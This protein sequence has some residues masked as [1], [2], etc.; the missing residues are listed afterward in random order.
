[1]K[2]QPDCVF[3]H[4]DLI[5]AKDIETWHGH[6]GSLHRV[7]EPPQPYTPGHLLV[8]PHAHVADAAEDALLTSMTFGVAA[9]VSRRYSSANI[10]TSIGTAA[11][12]TVFHLHVHVVPR[13][14]GDGLSIW[15]MTS[16][17]SLPW[18]THT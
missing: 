1:M 14:L 10:L 11:T 9:R 15:M 16:S 18:P 12:Q 17:L 4:R 6:D 3:C 13:T 5:K 8:V 7:F 2:A